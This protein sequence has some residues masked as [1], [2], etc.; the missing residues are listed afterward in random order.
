MNRK[1]RYEQNKM[2]CFSI[3]HSRQVLVHQTEKAVVAVY[4]KNA[5]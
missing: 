5:T 3:L 2:D 4:T 1:R